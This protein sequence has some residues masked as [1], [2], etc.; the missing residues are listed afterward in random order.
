MRSGLFSFCSQDSRKNCACSRL[1]LEMLSVYFL[2]AAYN[3]NRCRLNCSKEVLGF[4]VVP[5][6]FEVFD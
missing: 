6:F 1:P 2:P 3:F 5:H 4:S